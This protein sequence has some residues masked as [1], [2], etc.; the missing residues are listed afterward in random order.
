MVAQSIKRSRIF[1]D[2]ALS[3]F[4]RDAQ[5]SWVVGEQTG[6]VFF[7]PKFSQGAHM[8]LTLLTIVFLVVSSGGKRCN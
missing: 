5:R 6:I 2:Q 7:F 4:F 8:E 3:N 1:G